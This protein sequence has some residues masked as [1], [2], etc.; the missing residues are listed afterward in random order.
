MNPK[1]EARGKKL[2]LILACTFLNKKSE[3]KTEEEIAQECGCPIED[4]RL[5]FSTI[6]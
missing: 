2:G 1:G 3:G 4:V 6:N 5:F